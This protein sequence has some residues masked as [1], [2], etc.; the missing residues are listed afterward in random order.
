[1]IL[2][3]WTQPGGRKQQLGL[4]ER[5]Q[6]QSCS[7]WQLCDHVVHSITRLEKIL[8]YDVIIPL[9]ILVKLNL[10]AMHNPLNNRHIMPRFLLK[11]LPNLLMFL[12]P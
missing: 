4:V 7:K 9:P 12:R 1:M 3:S 8:K 11:P 10:S 5:L 2:L 6:V